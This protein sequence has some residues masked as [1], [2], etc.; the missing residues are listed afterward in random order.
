MKYFSSN[1]VFKNTWEQVTGAFWQK[2]PNPTSKHVISEDTISRNVEDNK[3]VSTRILSKT[4]RMPRWGNFVFGNNARHVYIVEET[5]V[6]PIKKVMTSYTRNIGYTRFMVLEEK[7]VYKA[8]SENKDWTVV[9]K[10]AWI[11]SNMYGFSR[12]LQAFG[13]ER[14]KTNILKSNRGLQYV[15][16]RLYP[17]TEKSN[18]DILPT[19]MSK[20]KNTAKTKAAK[21]AAKA[22]M[23]Q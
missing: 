9:E 4:N 14:Y 5:V 18:V 2:Y 16:D 19:E 15:I 1:I 10:E 6:D 8:S 13:L 23:C 22:G 21:M 3:L 20:M 7:C 11:N 17:T 12:P